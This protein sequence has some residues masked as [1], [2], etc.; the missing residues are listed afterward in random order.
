VSP[1]KIRAR[2][3]RLDRKV[4]HAIQSALIALRTH[5]Y[6]RAGMDICNHT[7]I[8]LSAHLALTNPDGVHIGDVTYMAELSSIITHDKARNIHADTY[9]GRNCYIGTRAVIS[10]GVRVGDESI[11]VGGTVVIE[12]VPSG[13]MVAG[14]PAR[15]LRSGLRTIRH[16]ILM[17]TGRVAQAEKRA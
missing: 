17:D 13:S 4:I 3:E 7:W 9:I 10:P 8:S 16:G 14:H 1:V 12:H 6:R 11:V 15:I 2:R 5:V